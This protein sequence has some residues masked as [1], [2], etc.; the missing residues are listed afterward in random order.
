MAVLYVCLS[1]A[2][3]YADPAVACPA[4]GGRLGLD[5]AS[6]H[7]ERIDRL[8][9]AQEADT[10]EGSRAARALLIQA[11]RARLAAAA[12]AAAKAKAKAA[13]EEAKAAAEEGRLLA[14]L[15]GSAKANAK[16]LAEL[17]KRVAKLEKPA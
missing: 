8:V 5:V 4:C 13:A 9:A 7:P 14:E 11:E 1:C 3:R 17:E 10:D 6:P 16:R 12:K 2:T 15:E